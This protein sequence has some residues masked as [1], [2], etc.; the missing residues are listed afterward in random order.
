[1]CGVCCGRLVCT[2]VSGFRKVGFP[3]WCLCFLYLI[4]REFSLF[5]L[6]LL[7]A[8][9]WFRSDLVVLVCV[10]IFR[11]FVLFVV[12]VWLWICE[13]VLVSEGW[14]VSTLHCVFWGVSGLDFVIVGGWFGCAC[15][16]WLL[17]WR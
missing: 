2:I 5:R 1:M 4:R 15:G 3:L 6:G 7:G 8:W 17:C 11:F 10:W 12:C 14:L 9:W 13:C 16:L